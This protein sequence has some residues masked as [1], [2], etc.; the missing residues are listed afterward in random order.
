MANTRILTG[1]LQSF[2]FEGET[3]KIIE[4]GMEDGQPYAEVEPSNP[5]LVA[6]IKER[7]RREHGLKVYLAPAIHA[8]LKSTTPRVDTSQ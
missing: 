2:R 5:D 6:A 1:A 7:L 4:C 8:F 3:Y